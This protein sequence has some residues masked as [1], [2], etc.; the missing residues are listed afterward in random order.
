M[1]SGRH[2]DDGK[3]HSA[4]LALAAIEAIGG[5]ILGV[6]QLR[7]P[8]LGT[9][10]IVMA[11]L[12]VAAVVV[13]FVLHP[14]DI[15]PER[16]KDLIKSAIRLQL[17][18]LRWLLYGLP[19]VAVTLLAFGAVWVSS[20]TSCAAP[21]DLRVLTAPEN[22]TALTGAAAR[23][24]AAGSRGGC[25]TAIVTVTA[26]SSIEDI[27]QGFAHGWATPGSDGTDPGAVSKPVSY[28]GPRPDIWI[29]DTT[30]AAV[31]A[32]DQVAGPD[33]SASG[34]SGG[35]GPA[36]D[37][38][39][40]RLDMDAT[41]G[42]S[43]MVIAVFKGSYSFDSREGATWPSLAS[44]LGELRQRVDTLARP[45]PQSSEA[46]LMATPTLYEA[47]KKSPL[48]KMKGGGDT[49]AEELMN[50][51]G[52]VAGDAAALLCRF[53]GQDA[54]RAA[55]PV[56]AA[57]V[58]P[59]IALA[60]YDSGA[61]M[62]STCPGG[63]RPSPQWRLYPYYAQ[64][65]PVLD[66]P[67]VHVRWPGEDSKARD[68]AVDDFQAW[69]RSHALGDDGLRTPSGELPNDAPMLSGLVAGYGP[70]ALPRRVVSHQPDYVDGNPVSLPGALHS[71]AGGRPQ[72][73]F[74][75]LLDVSGSMAEPLTGGESR[76]I[77][78]QEI[79]GSVVASAREGDSMAFGAF[80]EN[81]AA[82]LTAGRR[83]DNE[84]EI[85]QARVNGGDL[86]LVQ[87]IDQAA[88]TMQFTNPG[89]LVVLT[90]GESTAKNP[91]ADTE[92][93]ALHR[94]YPALHVHFVLTGPKTCEDEPIK[95]ISHALGGRACVDG[96][97]RS[98]D[99][100]AGLV[101]TDVLW[102]DR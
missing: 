2:G 88:A 30:L 53:R 7:L 15:S 67:F 61:P 14:V 87:A 69:L 49:K 99:D 47:L 65:L 74:D 52:L 73:P 62:G 84:Q 21:V 18:A 1:S 79:A 3:F 56:R 10:L 102:G 70:D 19:G 75:L 32:R 71:Y 22:V 101:M 82:R 68:H 90:D 36:G 63:A 83:E 64:D 57:V 50:S 33:T 48:P 28:L 81:S 29:P 66:H 38:V 40:A 13:A 77:R 100:T 54:Q 89:E 96:S 35:D 55:P 91:R 58:V 39:S 25:R 17:G 80:S 9:L 20:G 31:D 44:L 76:L 72:T 78:A 5:L 34:R 16:F 86:A 93:A 4:S 24:V 98:P 60:Q 6:L 51:G 41:I 11:V 23:Y 43:P 12:V 8:L 59:E 46:A 27:K 45:S 37:D 42:T 85:Q 97:A 95:T 94:K 92:A 26:G